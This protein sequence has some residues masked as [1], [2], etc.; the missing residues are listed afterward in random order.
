MR[1]ASYS[2]TKRLVEDVRPHPQNGFASPDVFVYHVSLISCLFADARAFGNFR[3]GP[4]APP[5]FRTLFDAE[6]TAV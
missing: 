3:I 2:T 5:D 4:L 1:L 6:L